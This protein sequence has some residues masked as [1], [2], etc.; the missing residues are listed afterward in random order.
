[1]KLKRNTKY[2]FYFILCLILCSCASET[3]TKKEIKTG[4]QVKKL[5][6]VEQTN[7]KLENTGENISDFKSTL[8][9]GKSDWDEEETYTDTLE[10]VEYNDDYDYAYALFKTKEGKEIQ[11]YTDVTISNF[12]KG[13]NHLVNWKVGRFYEAGEGEAIYYQESIVDVELLN[14][15]FSFEQ[16]LL[17]F[18]SQYQNDKQADLKAHNHFLANLVTTY[19]NG[20]YCVKGQPDSLTKANYLTENFT[21]SAES[22]EGDICAGYKDALDGLYY[23]FFD[24]R[25]NLFPVYNDMVEE[26]AE[27]TL[28]LT[29]DIIYTYYAKVL[30]ITEEQFN[31][32]LYFFMENN[33]WYFWVEDFCDCSA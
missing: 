14:S 22:P 12:Y 4:T 25:S 29:E 27:R 30:V 1:M 8:R 17:E 9:S 7:D 31:R 28:Y 26:G 15:S 18:S 3:K 6:S 16:F 19:K 24:E 2:L 10:L 13:R 11:I 5:D 23:E 20:L 21:I 33:V 32:A